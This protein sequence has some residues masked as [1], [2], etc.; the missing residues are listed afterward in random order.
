MKKFIV[1]QA[2]G[3]PAGVLIGLTATQADARAHALQVVT[4]ATKSKNGVY[5]TTARV[6]FK[7]GEEIELDAP[8]SKAMQEHLQSPEDA[9]QQAAATQKAEGERAELDALRAKA[10]AWDEFQTQ[11][12]AEWEAFKVEADQLRAKAAAWDAL[13]EAVRAQHTA[14]A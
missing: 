5:Q 7:R 9:Q 4:K 1:T 3:L 14:A 12:R 6:E 2:L 11:G 8:P 10:A 13:P